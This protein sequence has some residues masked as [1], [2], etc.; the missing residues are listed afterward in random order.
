M[1]MKANISKILTRI[2]LIL[3]CIKAHDRKATMC[4]T[5]KFC[6]LNQNQFTAL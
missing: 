4:S 1:K 3:S 2:L 6:I 5:K